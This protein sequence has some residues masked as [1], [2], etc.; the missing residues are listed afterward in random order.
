MVWASTIQRFVVF[1]SHVFMCVTSWSQL[2]LFSLL[3][4]LLLRARALLM[5]LSGNSVLVL[6]Y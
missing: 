5:P 4:F 3:Q 2:L 6:I 1:D